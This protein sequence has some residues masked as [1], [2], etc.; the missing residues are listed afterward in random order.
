MTNQRDPDTGRSYR[1]RFYRRPDDN[2][3]SW[4]SMLVGV[5]IVLAIIFVGY[6]LLHPNSDARR[7]SAEAPSATT[8]SPVPK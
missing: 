2:N 1:N 6:S 4:L 5:V 3:T 8:P 7:T